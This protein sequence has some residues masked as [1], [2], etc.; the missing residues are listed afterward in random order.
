MPLLAE[1]A[2][3]GRSFISITQREM[4]CE[5]E[6]VLDL[7]S[8]LLFSHGVYRVLVNPGYESKE[9]NITILKEGSNIRREYINSAYTEEE[10]EEEDSSN[11]RNRETAEASDAEEDVD[12][13]NVEGGEMTLQDLEEA[14]DETINSLLAD[15]AEVIVSQMQRRQSTRPTTRVPRL[16]GSFLSGSSL[17]RR[18]LGSSSLSGLR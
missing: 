8:M 9:L 18:R 11:S 16:R 2:G 10:E 1:A 15:E 5:A 3:D 4:V 17:S 7:L 13:E 6:K 12:V 14:V